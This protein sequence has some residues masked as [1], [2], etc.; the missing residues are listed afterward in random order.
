M[1][2]DCSENK[3]VQVADWREMRLSDVLH[4]MRNG[5]TAQQVSHE[6]D[7]PVSRIETI[8]SGYVDQARVGYL[9][10]PEPSFLLRP[11]DILYSH[12]NSVNHIG[13]SAIYTGRNPLYH[14][15]NLMLLR[16]N[17]EIVL[18]DYLA[19]ILEMPRSRAHARR[20]CK[21][22]INQASLGQRQ[23]GSL[24]LSL[25]SLIEQCMITEILDAAA[26][27]I[28]WTEQLIAKFERAKQGVL[29]D[30]LTLGID[31]SG[32]L[33]DPSSHPHMFLETP[34]GIFPRVWKVGLL[35]EVVSKGE[36]GISL[37]LAYGS[38][39][40]VLRMNN[41]HGG[42][43]T[44]ADIKSCALP[45]PSQLFLRPGDVL[46]NRTNSMD[47]VGRSGIWRGGDKVFS[48][49]SYLVRLVHD[50]KVMLPQY[51]NIWLNYSETQLNLRK[52]A[53]PGVHQVNVNPPNLRRVPIAYPPSITEQSAI[54]ERI[55]AVD[56]EIAQL[57]RELRQRR[58]IKRGLMD[59]LLTGRVRVGCLG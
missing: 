8:S 17:A 21:P 19:R 47:H 39:I 58:L 38:G 50:P 48:F 55:E 32:K 41:I 46:F 14:G 49:A 43:I 23:I 2:R 10:R 35:G 24:R 15:M 9:Q 31:E 20:E 25:P 45:I 6:T 52:Y 7:F 30:L 16:A 12:I 59:D 37:P 5:T 34:I 33:R 1:S 42:E 29:H 13:K 56:A 22:A 57:R 27:T 36:Y 28:R 44:L 26:D 3:R 54:C 18:P 4:T 11:G 51:L 53:T 40:P